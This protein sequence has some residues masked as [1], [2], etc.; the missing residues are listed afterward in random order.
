MQAFAF[1]AVGQI[2]QQMRRLDLKFLEDFHADY[3][4]PAACRT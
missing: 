3:C 1:V 2:G 4:N